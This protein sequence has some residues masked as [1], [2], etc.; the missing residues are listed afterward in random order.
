MPNEIKRIT[1]DQP[2]VS[3]VFTL[4]FDG[5]QTNTLGY[6]AAAATVQSELE[7]LSN[8]GAGNVVVEDTTGGYKLTFQGALANTSIGD[9]LSVDVGALFATDSEGDDSDLVLVET[10]VEGVTGVNEIQE[11]FLNGATTGTFILH[12]SDFDVTMDVL[13]GD[14]QSSFDLT[15]GFGSVVISAGAF[16]WSSSFLVEFIGARAASDVTEMTVTDNMTDS[17]PYVTTHTGGVAPVREEKDFTLPSRS[18]WAINLYWYVAGGSAIPFG[19]DDATVKTMLEAAFAEAMS[20]VTGSGGGPYHATFDATGDKSNSVSVACSPDVTIDIVQVGGAGADNIAAGALT[21]GA[22]ILSGSATVTQNVATGAL[23]CGANVIAGSATVTQNL[24]T[25]ALTCGATL[26]AGQA[27]V[28]QNIATAALTSGATTIAGQA[29][30]TQN[31]ATGALTCGQALCSG[32]AAVTHYVATGALTTGPAAIAGS[33]NVTQNIATAAL[34]CGA[35]LIAGQV[36]VT[37]NI[38][39]AVLTCGATVIAGQAI[40][41]RNIAS[42]ALTSGP[43]LCSGS[44]TT[45]QNLATGSLTIG[46]AAIAG[47]ANVTQNVA[48]AALTCGVSLIAGQAVVTQNVAHAA[49]TCGATVIAGQAIV[50]QNIAQAALQLSPTILVGM[51][52]ASLEPTSIV[53]AA[54]DVGH[55]NAAA[56]ESTVS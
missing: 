54:A 25:A 5:E 39:T 13:A 31:I 41:T 37:Q 49:L 50:T 19:A 32:S 55:P 3:G 8:I 9:V 30:V 33:A 52:R 29:V 48:T 26:I 23:T 43:L 42:G 44:A 1:F 6:A 14:Y 35:L 16:G 38:A 21:C 11:V 7:G 22:P 10:A 51:C 45:T 47:A 40:V 17:A 28:T 36:V 46:P 4:L 34:T 53:C 15:I 12:G 56:A 24:A 27:V 18:A 20:S 2:P